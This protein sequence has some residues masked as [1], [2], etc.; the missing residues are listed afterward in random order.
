LQGETGASGEGRK[1]EKARPT[2]CYVFNQMIFIMLIRERQVQK[3]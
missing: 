2:Y 3:D 1:G